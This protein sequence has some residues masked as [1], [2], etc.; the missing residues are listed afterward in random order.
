[1]TWNEWKAANLPFSD[2]DHIRIE[3]L[4]TYIINCSVYNVVPVTG[5]EKKMEGES[6]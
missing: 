3:A 1:M 5:Y 2:L 4:G 6:C